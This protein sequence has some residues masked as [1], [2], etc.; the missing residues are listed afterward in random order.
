MNYFNQ[1]MQIIVCFI[2]S[3]I[4]LIALFVSSF[5]FIVALLNFNRKIGTN[6][7]GS[8]VVRESTNSN[9]VY[10]DQIILQN[11]K[12]AAIAIYAIY[13]KMGYN[14]YLLVEQFNTEPFIIK[15]YEIVIRKYGPVENYKIGLMKV[16]IDKLLWNKKKNTLML[17]TSYGKYIVQKRNKHW[18]PKTVERRNSTVNIINPYY[19]KYNGEI[20]GTNIKYILQIEGETPI[21]IEYDAYIDKLFNNFSLTYDSLSSAENL[22][23]FLV[24]KQKEGLFT[25]KKFQVHDFETYRKK[26]DRFSSKIIVELNNIS[27]FKYLLGKSKRKNA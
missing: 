22:V 17:S 27:L 8:Y 5:A 1:A 9:Y 3:N 20:I 19:S 18:S 21:P 10:I 4:S 23:L 16:D 24:E 13:I 14:N 7:S 6:I 12:D 25:S 15:P 26:M 11:N 2:K